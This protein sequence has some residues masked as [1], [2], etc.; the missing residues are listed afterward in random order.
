MEQPHQPRRVPGG[1]AAAGVHRLPGLGGGLRNLATVACAALNGAAYATGA[2]SVD[3]VVQNV[4]LEEVDTI[5]LEGWMTE[6]VDAR[7]G[8]VWC[9]NSAEDEGSIRRM[10]EH[11]KSV[12][13]PPPAVVLDL[14]FSPAVKGFA[15][16]AS[17]PY[18]P[19]A[20]DGCSTGWVSNFSSAY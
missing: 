9:I 18:A 17:V 10:L 20:G 12:Q 14:G 7:Q 8:L 19:Y 4:P 5:F 2:K 16:A 1:R 15:Q 6:T 11:R 3:C 13:M